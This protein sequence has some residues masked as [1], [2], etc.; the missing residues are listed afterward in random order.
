MNNQI[1]IFLVGLLTLAIVIFLPLNILSKIDDIPTREPVTV[2]G[3]MPSGGGTI[4]CDCDCE[5]IGDLESCLFWNTLFGLGPSFGYILCGIE[6]SECYDDC[7]GSSSST[8][9]G[10]GGGSINN[11]PLRLK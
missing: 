7:G 5:C 3:D 10:G 8:T 4:N 1:K 9:G 2:G 6:L 11:P